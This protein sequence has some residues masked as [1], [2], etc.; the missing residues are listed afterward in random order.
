MN[1]SSLSFGSFSVPRLTPGILPGAIDVGIPQG[2][3]VQAIIEAI[4]EEVVLDSML[5]HP[6]V[7]YGVDGVLLSH[8]ALATLLGVIFRLPPVKQLLA[9]EQ[10]HSRYLE[11]LIQRLEWQ[12]D[13][14]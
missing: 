1:S 6:V 4:E 10:L 11:S 9:S 8:R 12:P 7:G 13:T 5:G 3:I 14:R 2:Y